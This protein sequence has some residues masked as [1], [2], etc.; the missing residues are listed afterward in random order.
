MVEYLQF[1]LEIHT[2]RKE[3][4]MEIPNEYLISYTLNNKTK[5]HHAHFYFL[6][7]LLFSLSFKLK[8]KEAA[9]ERFFLVE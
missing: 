8:K 4:E 5:S 6:L 7:L 2:E 3:I 9:T 1:D